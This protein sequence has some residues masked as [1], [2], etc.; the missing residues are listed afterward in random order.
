MSSKL[1]FVNIFDGI[2]SLSVTPIAERNTNIDVEIKTAY[3]KDIYNTDEF[4]STNMLNNSDI[5]NFYYNIILESLN[6]NSEAQTNQAFKN[7]LQQLKSDFKPEGDPS[8]KAEF[9]T[10]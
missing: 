2:N 9:A 6:L 5:K 4:N 3:I 8:S 10:G 1:F 7:N